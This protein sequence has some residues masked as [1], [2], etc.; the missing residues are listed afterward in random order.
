M[1]LDSRERGREANADRVA[2]AA[3]GPAPVAPPPPAYP[4]IFNIFGRDGGLFQPRPAPD[5]PRPEPPNPVAQWFDGNDGGDFNNDGDFD[6]ID[7]PSMYA[8]FPVAPTTLIRS[9]QTRR[10]EPRPPIHPRNDYKPY[11]RVLQQP[12]EQY[13]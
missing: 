5:P 8:Q 3:A 9:K 6:W 4:R 2:Q 7:D 1:L 10:C 12:T 11:L 13:E